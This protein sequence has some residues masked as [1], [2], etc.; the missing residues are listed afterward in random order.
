MRWSRLICLLILLAAWANAQADCTPQNIKVG[1][2]ERRMLVC[3]NQK[4]DPDFPAP[5]VLAFHGRGG[6]AE[7]MAQGTRIH[8]AWPD[9]IVVYLEGLTGNPAPYD[10]QGARRGWQINPGELQDRD[11]R[12]TDAALDALNMQY[13]LDAGRVYAVGHSNGARF[14]GILWAKRA[15]RFAAF[16]FSAGQADALIE[17]A[18]P[19]PVFI[20]MGRRDEIIPFE[21]QRQSIDYARK[22]LKTDPKR[23][24]EFGYT[25][26]ES[27]A[28][29]LE[30]MTYVHPGGHIWPEVQTRLT[31]EFFKRHRLQT[32][33]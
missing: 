32:A 9:A 12:F 24:A 6:S 22:L 14:A 11:L 25:R 23:A 4:E 19:R 31:V 5:L 21:W 28:G 30:L 16:A 3:A 26:S 1:N 20:S 8:D 15:A 18:V 7:N 29:E 17:H 13:K 2:A 27:G 10:P 33:F